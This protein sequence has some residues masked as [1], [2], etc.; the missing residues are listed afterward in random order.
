MDLNE[1]AQ[2]MQELKS[3]PFLA[4][5]KRGY[6]VPKESSNDPNSILQHLLNTKQIT[7][8][9]YNVAYQRAMMFRNAQQSNNR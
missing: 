8:E 6:Q 5:L 1:F 7:Q 4:L 9:Q 3:N 2:N